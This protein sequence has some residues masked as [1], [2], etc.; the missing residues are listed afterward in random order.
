MLRCCSWWWLSTLLALLPLVQLPAQSAGVPLKPQ[1]PC[2]GCELPLRSLKASSQRMRS[3]LETLESSLTASAGEHS[4]LQ[5]SLASLSATLQRANDELL[6]WREASHA[7]SAQL[8]ESE[9]SLTALTGRFS[10]LNERLQE[11]E[12]VA[13]TSL[14]AREAAEAKATRAELRLSHEA[15]H[16]LTYGALGLGVGA[17]LGAFVVILIVS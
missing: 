16:R 3:E 1:A 9:R 2:A 10:G 7:L 14:Q 4:G 12:R 15:G 6:L 17:I 11:A 8:E 5:T 13:A